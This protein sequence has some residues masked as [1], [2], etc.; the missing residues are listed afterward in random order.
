M[1]IFRQNKNFLENP[2]Y[3]LDENAAN[4][5]GSL[6]EPIIWNDIPKYSISTSYKLPVKADQ[7]VL[8]FFLLECQKAN[9]VKKLRFTKYGIL[10]A[11]GIATNGKSYKRLEDTL[12]RLEKLHIAYDESFTTVSRKHG[13]NH[14]SSHFG[15]IDSWSKIQNSKKTTGKC[16]IHIRLSDEFVDVI[17]THPFY[18]NLNF[19]HLKL[20]K[21][22]SCFRIYELIVKAF[23]QRKSWSIDP[24]LFA[25]KIPLKVRWPSD[26]LRKTNS[27]LKQINKVT[28]PMEYSVSQTKGKM[29]KKIL[30]FKCKNLNAVP[31]KGQLHLPL[32]P[33]I[34]EEPVLKNMIPLNV[35]KIMTKMAMNSTDLPRLKKKHPEDYAKAMAEFNKTRN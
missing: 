11:C 9:W 22:P 4:I 35:R 24:M 2:L 25:E 1:S 28:T 3:I 20:L 34:P 16:E 19:E 26:V 13:I 5:P 18:Q 29:K 33:V 32:I 10:K 23:Y 27:A 30:T 12:M 14:I 31:K 8:Y 6:S 17:R 15:I 21:T 7:L